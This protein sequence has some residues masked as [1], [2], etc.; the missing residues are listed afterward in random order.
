MD[1][2]KLVSNI[3]K[4]YFTKGATATSANIIAEEILNAL[5]ETIKISTKIKELQQ[6]KLD[7]EKNYKKGIK[8]KDDVIVSLQ[9]TCSHKITTYY[10]DPSGN[11]DAQTECDVCG[12]EI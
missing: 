2:V 1:K 6:D 9:K 10:P 7:Y 8:E 5:A 3:V 11:S 4:S 12:A